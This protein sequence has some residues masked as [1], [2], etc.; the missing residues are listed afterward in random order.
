[1]GQKLHL[2]DLLFSLLDSIYVWA[3]ATAQCND[4]AKWNQKVVAGPSNGDA[5][6]HFKQ[7]LANTIQNLLILPQTPK[8]IFQ[9]K[10]AREKLKPGNIESE[11]LSSPKETR[12]PLNDVVYWPYFYKIWYLRVFVSQVGFSNEKRTRLWI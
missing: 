9:S 7:W 3:L 8:W 12:H 2:N 4:V 5:L 6:K 10:T 11:I 1:M